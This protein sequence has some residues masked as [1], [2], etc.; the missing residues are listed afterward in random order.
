MQIGS[1]IHLASYVVGNVGNF[2]RG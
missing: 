2:P 1:R